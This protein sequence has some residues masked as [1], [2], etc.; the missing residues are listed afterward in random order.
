MDAKGQAR[1]LTQQM[2]RGDGVTWEKLRAYVA[3]RGLDP[4]DVAVATRF[5]ESQG[6]FVVLLT[7]DD[8]AFSLVLAPGAGDIRR[9]TADAQII[10]WKELRSAEERYPYMDW[11]SGA[12]ESLS[13]E[14]E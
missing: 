12:R 6:D 10:R 9:Q 5:S 8:R 1:M 14:P 13:D 3:Q 7:R 2:R 4:G 11:L